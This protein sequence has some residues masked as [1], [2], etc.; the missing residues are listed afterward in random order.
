[1]ANTSAPKTSSKLTFKE[2][3]SQS[4][5]LC[6]GGVIITSTG[7]CMG[8]T[9]TG[10]WIAYLLAGFAFL[11]TV[12]PQLIAASILPKTSGSYYYSYLISPKMGGFYSYLFL[13]TSITISFAASSFGTYMEDLLPIFNFR[14]WTMIILTVFFLLNLMDQKSVVKAQTLLNVV[15]VVGWVSFLILG[16]PKV[17]WEVFT[18]A[19]MFPNGADGMFQAVATLVFGVSSAVWVVDAGERLENPQKN[20][21]KCNM[22]VVICCITLFAVISVVAAG[23]VP[24]PE[25]VN[26]PLTA[27]ARA[28]YPGQSYLVFIIGACIMALVTTVNGRFTH[29]CVGLVR[30]SQ[31]GWFPEAMCKTNR[32]GVPYIFMICVYALSMIPS[33]TGMDMTLIN[34]MAAAVTNVTRILPNIGLLYIIKKFP[35]KWESSRFYMSK[36][37]LTV[38]MVVCMGTLAFAIYLNMRSFTPVMWIASIALIV[39][40]YVISSLRCKHAQS[41]IAQREAAGVDDSTL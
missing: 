19:Q 33:V 39:A 26:K 23:V 4:M 2:M 15:M 34:Q 9:G 25:V 7:I 22:L 40:F 21:F 29:S 3:F 1:M 13:F 36:P 31:E 16:V 41:I 28:L 18:P 11:L 5:G 17:N 8:Y 35:E 32:F 10:V 20:I 27:V 6:I 30:C 24:L 12:A 37:V 38:F 14:V